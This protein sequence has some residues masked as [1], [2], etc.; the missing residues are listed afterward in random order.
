[1]DTLIYLFITATLIAAALASLAIWAPRRTWV[2]VSALA[3][4]ALL[5]PV[6]Y[7]QFV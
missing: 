7:V 5:I 4:A 6:S 2:R 1:M 3:V